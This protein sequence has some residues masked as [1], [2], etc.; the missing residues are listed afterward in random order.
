VLG[1]ERTARLTIMDKTDP[2]DIRKE[3]TQ[4]LVRNTRDVRK[5]DTSIS[6]FPYFVLEARVHGNLAPL[7]PA[8]ATQRTMYVQEFE[9]DDDFNASTFGVKTGATIEFYDEDSTYI[10]NNSVPQTYGYVRSISNQGQITVEFPTSTEAGLPRDEDYIKIYI[11]VR[12]GDAV[13]VANP[14]E[15]ILGN[16]LLMIS[17]FN[18]S[19]GGFFTKFQTVGDNEGLPAINLDAFGIGIAVD[20]GTAGAFVDNL[21]GGQQTAAF[22]G[23]LYTETAG[24]KTRS[25][26]VSWGNGN[27]TGTPTDCFMTL[28]DGKI[29]RI[30]ASNTYD[31]TDGN[32]VQLGA[33]YQGNE[34]GITL[35]PGHP[36][37]S[38]TVEYIVYL[39]TGDVPDADNAFSLHTA[40]RTAAG[41]AI[42]TGT[43]RYIQTSDR[44]A[45][46]YVRNGGSGDAEWRIHGSSDAWNED[47]V[48]HIAPAV[49]VPDSFTATLGKK[50]LQP[51]T[52]DIAI[53]P[54]KTTSTNTTVATPTDLNR[55]IHATLITNLAGT[56]ANGFISFA[57]NS[58]PILLIANNGSTD[59]ATMPDLDMGAGNSTLNYIYFKLA[60]SSNNETAVA[61]NVTQAIIDTTTSYAAATSDSRGLLAIV[62]TGSNASA[63]EVSIQAFHGK[64]QNITADVIA[65]DAVIAK[66]IKAGSLD[67]KLITLTGVDGLIRTSTTV[68]TTGGSN[69]H[70]VKIN[71]DGVKGFNTAGI[72]QFN[73]RTTDG[74]AVFGLT[75]ATG[76]ADSPDIVAASGGSKLDTDGITISGQGALR[77]NNAPDGEIAFRM[78][79]IVVDNAASDD[80][81]QSIFRMWGTETTNNV[82]SLDREAA[83]WWYGGTI[84]PGFG[85]TSE[86]ATA[87]FR[88]SNLGGT[89]TYNYLNPAAVGILDGIWDGEPW[90]TMNA[91]EIMLWDNSSAKYLA[92][93]SNV[94]SGFHVNTPSY[95]VKIKVAAD[96]T[97][98]A[99]STSGNAYSHGYTMILPAAIGAADEVLKVS[100]VSTVNGSKDEMTLEWG[101]VSGSGGGD[102]T[103]VTA[104]T[105]LSGGGTTGTV[106]LTN[107]GITATSGGV[108]NRVALYSDTTTLLGDSGLYYT[109]S[110][111][112]LSINGILSMTVARDAGVTGTYGLFQYDTDGGDDTHDVLAFASGQDQAAVA[113]GTAESAFWIMSSESDGGSG[114]RL[115]FEPVVAFISGSTSNYASIGYHNPLV[116]IL[117]YYHSAGNGTAAYPSITF[118]GNTDN[119]FWHNTVMGSST[120]SMSLAGSEEYVFAPTYF[121]SKSDANLG[122]S[123]DRWN[124][125]YG[126]STNMSSD[127]RLKENIVNMTN[128]LDIINALEP[129]EYTRIPDESKIQHFG[130]SAQ[131]VKEVMLGLGYAENTIYSEESSEEKDSADWGINLPELIA[132]LV[133]AI[134]ELSAKVKKLEEEK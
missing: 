62:S 126:V 131:H 28:G 55:Y 102:I 121:E 69:G 20:P 5:G 80:S 113:S 6:G 118:Y 134:Q 88:R 18:D 120:I 30:N 72:S 125:V 132:P 36:S 49:I 124:T 127:I 13:R 107:D 68:G 64:G 90:N 50:T 85:M 75:A 94:N 74:A 16:H 92:S 19:Q 44:V 40:P 130:F 83:F 110:T 24:G 34:S 133:S 73:L 93:S 26:N 8:I 79:G 53:H 12:A 22:N 87:G 71:S 21:P 91:R 1:I 65:A 101:T 103:G 58:S 10:T 78:D 96:V 45:A 48:R 76:P 106:T 32:D 129:I 51:Y 37:A 25:N 11:P 33:L 3:I 66:A 61:A 52:V 99:Y 81:D 2:D 42:H 119:G 31:S 59:T 117:S 116:S 108:E 84:S 41:A 29:Y 9:D 67:S 122:E 104:G 70:G 95:G 14:L 111:D 27:L 47:I 98:T 109:P 56:R 89:P 4:A 86:H 63:D 105:G 97:P 112:T 17:T 54:G 23:I 39:D 35:P 46:F 115:I 77:F 128:G 82:E 7:N 43:S 114:S 123:G 38:K 60:D 100:S 57:D 15:G